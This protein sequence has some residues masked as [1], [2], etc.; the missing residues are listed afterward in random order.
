MRI[1]I[2]ED[3]LTSSMFMKKYLSKYGQCDVAMN[4]IEG[5]DLAIEAYESNMPYDLICLDIMMP[6]VDGIKVL[7]TIRDYEK[8]KLKP[9]QAISKI[10]MTT[11]LNNHETVDEAYKIGC[12]GY[13]WKPIV[14][15]EF[16]KVLMTLGLI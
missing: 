8:S 11:A 13:A 15:E 2:V 1:L 5:I 3:D 6:K 16:N 7:K 4:G 10:I 14:I 12:E 9:D